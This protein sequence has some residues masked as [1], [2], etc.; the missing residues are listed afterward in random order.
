MLFGRIPGVRRSRSG[1]WWLT[2]TSMVAATLVIVGAMV[3][4]SVVLGR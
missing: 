1:V 4:L 2:V 3:G